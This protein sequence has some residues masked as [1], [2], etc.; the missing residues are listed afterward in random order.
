MPRRAADASD[1][2]WL[3]RIARARD[4]APRH[5]AAAEILT[6]YAGLAERQRAIF[7]QSTDADDSAVGFGQA[8]DIAAA[9]ASI[10]DF[11]CWLQRD[12]PAPLAAA[13]RQLDGIDSYG[14]WRILSESLSGFRAPDD[15]EEVVTFVRDATI[16]PI[17]E[18]LAMSRRPQA[19]P[20]TGVGDAPA[21]CPICRSDPVVGALREDAEGARRSLL[22]ARCLTEWR[23]LRSHCPRCDER[24]FEALPVYTADEFPHVRVEACDTCHT[25]LKTIDFTKNAMAVPVVDDLASL[26]LDLWARS[27]GYTR[28]QANILRT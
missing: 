25:Y 28:L 11:L 14:W 1:A 15:M 9:L 10:P 7:N 13:A 23:F 19:P 8:V 24:R 17:A 18:A 12:A 22:C 26:T 27:A 6:F 16:Q 20:P 2:H 21:H 4:L 5:P 3:E